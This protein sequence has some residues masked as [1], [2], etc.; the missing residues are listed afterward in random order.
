LKNLDYN[1]T[2]YGFNKEGKDDNLI[3]RKFN[4]EIFYKDISTSKAII[5]NGG[6]T[7]ISEALY[8]RKPIFSLPLNQFEQI[9]NAKYIKKIGVGD[10]K[11]K[12]DNEA[13]KLFLENIDLYKK[14]L[15]NYDPGDQ[16]EILKKIDG[17]IE[18]SLT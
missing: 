6:F 5:T 14:N 17:V 12:V 18:S 16:K 3:F 1:F 9:L 10:Y 4:L 2:I 7:V 15:D 8:L 11:K 13:I